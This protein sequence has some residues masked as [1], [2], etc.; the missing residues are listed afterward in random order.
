MITDIY[1][2]LNLFIFYICIYIYIYYNKNIEFV[3]KL[4]KKHLKIKLLKLTFLNG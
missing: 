3:K 4:N 1:K 2:Y